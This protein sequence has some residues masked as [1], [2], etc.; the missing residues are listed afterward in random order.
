MLCIIF[1]FRYEVKEVVNS[2]VQ[3]YMDFIVW[4]YLFDWVQMWPF[5]LFTTDPWFSGTVYRLSTDMVGDGWQEPPRWNCE[6]SSYDSRSMSSGLSRL[7]DLSVNRLCS[8]GNSGKPVLAQHCS[9]HFKRLHRQHSLWPHASSC[10]LQYVF[11]FQ[12][13]NTFMNYIL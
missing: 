4:N 10:K 7:L 2:F 11:H 12:N 3:P 1:I 5:P 8:R 6:R 9:R 13:Y